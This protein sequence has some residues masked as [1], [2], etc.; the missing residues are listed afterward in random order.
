MG[1]SYLNGIY[2]HATAHHISEFPALRKPKEE[3]AQAKP[4][5]KFLF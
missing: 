1:I 3:L 4:F 5:F 2:F